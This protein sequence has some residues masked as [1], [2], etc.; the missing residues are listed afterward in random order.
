MSPASTWAGA[1]SEGL[2]NGAV[3]CRDNSGKRRRRR[4]GEGM[5][6]RLELIEHV[7]GLIALGQ[8]A[9]E[10]VDAVLAELAPDDGDECPVCGICP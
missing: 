2:G 9:E 10:I 1:Q 7:A 8:S 3:F 6:D 4:K 5:K